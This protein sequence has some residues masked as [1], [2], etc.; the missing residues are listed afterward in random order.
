MLTMA[1]AGFSTSPSRSSRDNRLPTDVS[2]RHRRCHASR[3]DTVISRWIRSATMAR[4]ASVPA[5]SGMR[6]QVVAVKNCLAMHMD[7]ALNATPPS[8]SRL[9]SPPACSTALVTPH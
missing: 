6:V 4:R 2:S 9:T 1:C 7:G 8:N 5:V 3:A